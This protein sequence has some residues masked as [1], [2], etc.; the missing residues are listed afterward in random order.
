MSLLMKFGAGGGLDLTYIGSDASTSDA[1]SYD[2]GN[3]SAASAGLMVVVQGGGRDALARTVSSISIGGSNGTLITPSS[4]DQ[5]ASIAY[6]EVSAGNNNVTVVYNSTAER[7]A[8]N[9]YLI[10]GY[11]SATPSDSAA[12]TT[13]SGSESSRAMAMTIPAG[14]VAVYGV[15]SA[16][17]GAISW[18]NATEDYDQLIES[19]F[20]ISSA[21]LI[22]VTGSHTETATFGG[23]GETAWA[24]ACWG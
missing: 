20:R 1:S 5:V 11:T 18:D 9:V 3:F 15:V 14:G 16:N 10:T 22:G 21:S 13:G 23:S 17:T 2:H 4:G 19:L 24:N 8:V 7:D 6:R 12:S